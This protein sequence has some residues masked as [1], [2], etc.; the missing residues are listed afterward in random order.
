M[1]TAKDLFLEVVGESLLWTYINDKV[2]DIKRFADHLASPNEKEKYLKDKVE[3][4]KEKLSEDNNGWLNKTF[5]RSNYSTCLFSNPDNGNRIFDYADDIIAE[6]VAMAAADIEEDKIDAYRNFEEGLMKKTFRNFLADYLVYCQL[7]PLYENEKQEQTLKDEELVQKYSNAGFKEMFCRLKGIRCKQDSGEDKP[8]IDGTSND[9]LRLFK[10]EKPNKP[11][12][13]N[14]KAKDRSKTSTL[15]LFE[16]IY[17]ISNHDWKKTV[18]RV[19]VYFGYKYDTRNDS[20]IKSKVQRND[21]SA[22]FRD[23]IEPIIKSFICK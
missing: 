6:N 15:P 13:W 12:T 3:A 23:K 11:L 17:E 16:L 7:V 14:Y 22:L 19:E 9:W 2:K 18:K 1:K 4:L 10:D 21:K 20:S 8:L 5:R